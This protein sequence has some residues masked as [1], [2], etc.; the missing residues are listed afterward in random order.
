[1][2]IKQIL[3]PVD[4]SPPSL[5]ALNYAV[6]LAGV[7]KAA[8]TVLF[9]VEP[10]YSASPGDIYASTTR[11]D[12]L[13]LEQQRAGREELTKIVQDLQK[14]GVKCSPLLE[15]GPVYQRINDAARRVKADLIVIG[16]HGRTGISHLLLGSVAE[17]VVQLAPCPVLT[18]RGAAKAPTKNARRK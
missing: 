16:T 8:L 4:F 9:V 10:V 17:R 2:A 14:K 18:V 15:T 6:D 3:V 13:L 12:M 5:A 1:M 7:L 11:A